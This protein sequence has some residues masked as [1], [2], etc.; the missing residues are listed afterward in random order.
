MSE[1]TVLGDLLVIFLFAVP[2]V[3]ILNRFGVPSIAGFILV[4]ILI[5]PK[6]IGLIENIH[7][8]EVFAEIGVALLLFGI[9]LELS[10]NKLRRL[11]R[12]ILIGGGLQVSGTILVAFLITK[13]LGQTP[14]QALFWGFLVAVSST[15][16]VL[17]GLEKR[18][19]LDAPHGRLTLGILVFQDLSVVPMMLVIPLLASS[20]SSGKELAM[21]LLKSAAILGGVLGASRI[22]VPR[23]LNMISATRQ[24][25]LFVLT[26]FLIC[27]GTAWIT[28][29]AGVSLALGAFL[30]GLIVAESEYRHQAFSEMIPFKM[31]L[32]SLF[33]ISIGMMLDPIALRH[34]FVPILLILAAILSLKFFL[35]FVVGLVMRLPLR[36]SILSAM[37]LAQVGEFSFVLIFA[38]D[39][40]N[41]LMKQPLDNFLIAAVLSMLITPLALVFAPHVAAGVGKL[42]MLTRLLDVQTAQHATMRKKQWHDHVII[43]GFGMT[44][45]MLADSLQG[46]QVEHVVVD[47]NPE[48][49]R[50]AIS[51]GVPA[52]FGDVTQSEV[53]NLL[54]IKRART[55]VVI[56]N[57]PDASERAV[58]A[59]R[60]ISANLHIFARTR[61]EIDVESLRAAGADDVVSAEKEA[62]VKVSSCV[63]AELGFL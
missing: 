20:G 26:I 9:G 52:Y 13:E 21:T 27:I 46:H 45:E 16:I 3:A 10:L 22:L 7:E 61:Y 49:V 18:D 15:A 31:I 33:F 43:A 54:G 32:T 19:E 1:M 30:A 51:D 39:K 59:A 47:L 63:L 17:R 2:I 53:L 42:S 5:G 56:I 55:L 60:G 28:S 24:R 40:T 44:G 36:V 23:I 48:N 57:D 34:N 12:P 29:F 62:A 11:W 37:A 38:A 4:G 25:D 50:R 35:V 6:A 14:Q 41:L 58:R 8:V